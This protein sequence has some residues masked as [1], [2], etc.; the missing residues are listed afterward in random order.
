MK[1]KEEPILMRATNGKD[2]MLVV[3]D[4]LKFNLLTVVASSCNI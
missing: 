1:N 2:T 4:R 3:L